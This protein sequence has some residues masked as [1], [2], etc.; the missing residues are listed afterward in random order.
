MPLGP[1]L[2]QATMAIPTLIFFIGGDPCGQIISKKWWLTVYISG[3]HLVPS[4]LWGSCTPA[5]H[6][7]A[8]FRLAVVKRYK[9]MG[10]LVWDEGHT[11][12]TPMKSA[13]VPSY[14][15]WCLKSES[16]MMIIECSVHDKRYICEGIHGGA[17]YNVEV[18]CVFISPIYSYSENEVVKLGSSDVRPRACLSHAMGC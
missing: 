2:F 13:A 10:G 3:N 9:N 1:K 16:H 14:M 12:P 17:A 4:I 6:L 8:L 15:M 5:C 18:V 11:T 7:I